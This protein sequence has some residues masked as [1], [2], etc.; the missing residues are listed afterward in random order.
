MSELIRKRD[1]VKAFQ[2]GVVEKGFGEIIGEFKKPVMET[3]QAPT[4]G[5]SFKSDTGDDIIST[6]MADIRDTLTYVHEMKEQKTVSKDA[7]LPPEY[8]A[9]GAQRDV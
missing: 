2:L 5:A 9:I 3:M 6:D 7:E 1:V 8:A 4:R